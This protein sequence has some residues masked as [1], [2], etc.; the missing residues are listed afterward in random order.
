MAALLAASIAQAAPPT[1]APAPG[2]NFVDTT[3][4]AFPVSVT[5]VVNGQTAKT[6]TGGRTIVTG[7]LAVEFAA[8]GKTVTLNISGPATITATASSV[9]VVGHGL[10][11]G[12]VN[13]PGGGITLG[14]QAGLVSID[15]N[16]GVGTLEHGTFL[17]DICAALAT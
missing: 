13:T 7:P 8:N 3:S 2:S 14:Y 12:P 10:G 6:F 5:F 9:T 17:L 1:I 15:P 4:C 11:A 16:T